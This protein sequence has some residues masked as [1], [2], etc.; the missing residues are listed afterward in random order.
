MM[1]VRMSF[2][3]MGLCL[4]VAIGCLAPG[5]YRLMAAPGDAPATKPEA[6]GNLRAEAA[7]ASPAK[8]PALGRR[9]PNFVL[10]EGTNQD[11]AAAKQ[12]GLADFHDKRT[13][14]LFFLSCQCPISNQYLPILNDIQSKY[15]GQGLQ[16]IGINS[17]AG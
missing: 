11:S 8:D 13:V 16:I 9:V 12:V 17:H 6:A 2:V 14:V 7:S 3:S 4:A 5:L 15:A 10:P 1:R